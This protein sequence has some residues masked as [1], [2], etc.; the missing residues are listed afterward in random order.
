MKGVVIMDDKL[1]EK[2]K[3]SRGLVKKYAPETFKTENLKILMEKLF[4]KEEA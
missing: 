4:K 1:K 3:K 2:L